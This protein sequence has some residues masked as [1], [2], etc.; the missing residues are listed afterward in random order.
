MNV[1]AL[2]NGDAQF[3]F[4]RSTVIFR[5]M[6]MNRTYVPVYSVYPTESLTVRSINDTDCYDSAIK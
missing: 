2:I 3:Y 5:F 4:Q 6:A 1:A